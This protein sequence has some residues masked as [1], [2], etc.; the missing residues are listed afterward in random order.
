MREIFH[1]FL[2][3]KSKNNAI[4]SAKKHKGKGDCFWGSNFV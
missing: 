1:C 3:K 4:M 2:L